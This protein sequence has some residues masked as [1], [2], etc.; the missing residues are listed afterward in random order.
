[1]SSDVE[2]IFAY[3]IKVKNNKKDKISLTIEDQLPISS[4]DDIAVKQID[5]SGGKVNQ[6]TK[7]ITWEVDVEAGKSVS[8]KM[9]YSVRYPKG[10]RINGL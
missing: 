10:S 3:E 4:N 5:I 8:K 6:E 9:I 7:I 2:R 1:L